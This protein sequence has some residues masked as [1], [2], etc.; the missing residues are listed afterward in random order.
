MTQCL[1][2]RNTH[3]LNGRARPLSPEAWQFWQLQGGVVG[4]ILRPETPLPLPAIVE[5]CLELAEE[6]ADCAPFPEEN[7]QYVAWCLLKLVEHDLAA[8]VLPTT[9][10]TPQP[11]YSIELPMARLTDR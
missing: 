7:E 5:A 9:R 6:Q 11:I 8:I 10:L 2:I 1:F 3:D 4:S